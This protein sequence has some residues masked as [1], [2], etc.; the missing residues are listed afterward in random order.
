M[1]GHSHGFCLLRHQWLFGFLSI[2]EC[3]KNTRSNLCNAL[4]RRPMADEEGYSGS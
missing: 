4:T 2:Q 1:N 3:C